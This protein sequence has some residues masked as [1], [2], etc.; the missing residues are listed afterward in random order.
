MCEVE[1]TECRVSDPG[2]KRNFDDLFKIEH[3]ILVRKGLHEVR[4]EKVV[5]LVIFQD[6]GKIEEA[7]FV[8]QKPSDIH[9]PHVDLCIFGFRLSTATEERFFGDTFIDILLN[10][11][12][13]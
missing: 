8:V 12:Q 9:D 13:I 11:F 6:G 5:A 4:L 7:L 1:E 10:F 3:P 2:D